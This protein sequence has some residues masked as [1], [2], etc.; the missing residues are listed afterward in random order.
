VA[1]LTLFAISWFLRRDTIS[2]PSALEYLLSFAGGGLSLLTGWLGGELV[3]QH[4]IGVN[5]GANLNAPSS[6]SARPPHGGTLA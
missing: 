6:L 1:V 2:D 5:E 3:D 4:A